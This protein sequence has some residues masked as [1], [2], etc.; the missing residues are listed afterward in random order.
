MHGAD[1]SFVRHG[2][3]HVT[4]LQPGPAFGN[5]FICSPLDCHKQAVVGPFNLAD[6][7]IFQPGALAHHEVCQ[8]F[9]AMVFGYF[10][11]L[12]LQQAFQQAF[13]DWLGL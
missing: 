9:L 3:D 13:I 1:V 4:Y 5:D 7:R 8:Y 6:R 2:Y 12:P 10:L 11:A